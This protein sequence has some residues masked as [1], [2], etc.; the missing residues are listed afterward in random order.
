MM[1]Y[2]REYLTMTNDVVTGIITKGV[3]GLYTVR[4]VCDAVAEEYLCRARGVFRH[5]KISPLPGDTVDIEL[6]DTVDD[7]SG[8]AGVIIAIHDRRNTLIRPPMANLSHMMIVVP[9]SSPKPDLFYIDKLTVFADANGIEC[10]IVVN[11][12]DLDGDYAREIAEEYTLAG[13]KT[14]LTDAMTG[15]G[16]TE[17]LDYIYGCRGTDSEGRCAVAAFAGVSGA[18]KSS[19]VGQL[20]PH[21][22]PEVGGVSRKT[23]RGRHTT[24]AVEL[25]PIADE[26]YLADTPGFS[27]LDFERFDFFEPEKLTAA[28]REFVPY[29]DQCRYADCTHTKEEECAVRDAVS[30]GKISLRRHES[31]VNLYETMKK[32]PDWQ[33]RNEAK[34]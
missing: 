31:F 23:E 28:F 12:C 24:R 8:A 3:G 1:N 17:V 10:A 33:R 30:E 32:K 22:A 14:F 29:L 34:K 25:Y 6:S 9:A 20:F 19:L 4:P 11:K 2:D 13:F 7:V 21:I 15:E 27:M 5:E 18:G 16:C 26:L